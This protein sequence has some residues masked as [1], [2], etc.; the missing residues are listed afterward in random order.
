MKQVLSPNFSK[1][2]KRS[3]LVI[4]L[5]TTE[6]PE[7][8]GVAANVANWFSQKASKVSAHYVVSATEVIQ[9]VEDKNQA[10]HAGKANG[11]SIGVEMCGKAGQSQSDWLDPFSR[12]MLDRAARLVANLC[13]VHDIPV[14]KL[15]P[16]DLLVIAEGNDVKGICGHVD[17]SKSLGG[18]HWDPGPAFPWLDFLLAVRAYVESPP[19]EAL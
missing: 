3:P 6:S 12:K 16:G 4:V 14:S 17:V 13:T 9:C 19:G 2:R 1:G 8:P 11:W 5:H 7:I 18:T 15:G 10:W